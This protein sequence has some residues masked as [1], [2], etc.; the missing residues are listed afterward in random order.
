MK[1]YLLNK[2]EIKDNI[3]TNP[4]LIRTKCLSKIKKIRTLQ[5]KLD[6]L[7][8]TVKTDLY[9]T[10]SGINEERITMLL[11]GENVD[12]ITRAD[13]NTL[14]VLCLLDTQEQRIK[15]CN[16]SNILKGKLWGNQ[17]K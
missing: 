13:Y 1:Y 9:S 3:W 6:S 8:K 5:K 14:L 11:K 4:I 15:T 17:I 7:L 16:K 10:N 12:E 2:D